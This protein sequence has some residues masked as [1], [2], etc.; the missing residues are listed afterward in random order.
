MFLLLHTSEEKAARHFSGG[1]FW[2]VPSDFVNDGESITEAITRARDA[3][4]VCTVAQTPITG[5]VT[6]SV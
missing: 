3:F 4:W 2:Q 6:V 5:R 1:R